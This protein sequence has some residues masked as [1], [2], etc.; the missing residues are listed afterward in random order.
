MATMSKAV[1]VLGGYVAGSTALREYLIHKARPFLF[2]TA[3]PPSVAAA[4]LESIRVLQE[5]P[6]HHRK[7]WENTKFF[8]SEL[9]RLGFDTAGSV[10]PITPI[11]VGEAA[12][13]M[14][15]SD[16]LFE[17]GVFAQGIG[18]PTVPEG[19]A[20]LR[21]IVTATHT[22]EDLEKALHAFAKVGKKLSL[23]TA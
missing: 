21:T 23:V 3:H 8:K 11:I 7:L 16:L 15:F 18:H 14:K 5:E 20:R 9:A 17:E 12:L 22:R 10:T 19:K 1:G 4:C 6:E 2:S 13:A